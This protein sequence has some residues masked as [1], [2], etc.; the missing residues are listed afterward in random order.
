M[1]LPIAFEALRIFGRTAWDSCLMV[2]ATSF[3]FLLLFP[4]FC[5][6][7]REVFCDLSLCHLVS[8]LVAFLS[9]SKTMGLVL[10]SPCK[11]CLCSYTASLCLPSSLPTHSWV[12]SPSGAVLRAL[13]R[14]YRLQVDPRASLS[15]GLHTCMSPRGDVTLL[16][17]VPPFHLS[18][19]FSCWSKCIHR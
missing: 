15:S 12:Q 14:R 3:A 13:Y 5:G 11:C 9:S 1:S 16:Y 17:T 2:L 10:V 18:S 6:V 19:G 8:S 7:N 4:A